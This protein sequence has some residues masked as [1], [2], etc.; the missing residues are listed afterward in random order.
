MLSSRFVSLANLLQYDGHM[1]LK[2]FCLRSRNLGHHSTCIYYGVFSLVEE[3]RFQRAGGRYSDPVSTP[4]VCLQKCQIRGQAGKQQGT[5]LWH[6]HILARDDAL[7]AEAQ[8]NPS[9]IAGY[10]KAPTSFFGLQRWL[11]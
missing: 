11:G 10:R 9:I 7:I 4:E 8:K 6:V 3:G 1:G 2:P 5:G